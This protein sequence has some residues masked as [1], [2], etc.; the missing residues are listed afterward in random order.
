MTIK[1]NSAGP[2]AVAVGNDAMAM[3]EFHD[4]INDIKNEHKSFDGIEEN[5]KS[6]PNDAVT[7]SPDERD[8]EE[9]I[10]KCNQLPIRFLRAEKGNF[11]KGKKRFEETLEWRKENKMDE[12]LQAEW[13]HFD[14]VKENWPHYFHLRG[15]QNEPVYYEMPPKMKLKPM[16]AAG[17]KMKDLLHHYALVTE[18]MWQYIESSEEGKSIYVI[19]LQG[20]GFWDFAGEI[21]DFCRKASKFTQQHYPE[22]AGTIFVINVPTFFQ[23]IYN[24]MKPMADPVTLEKIKVV[25][26]K[27]AVQTA[28]REKILI[29]N[30]PPQYGGTSVPLGESPEEKMF[31]E[32]LD[33]NN[34]LH[35]GN[36]NCG[37]KDGDPP[38]QFCSFEVIPQGGKGF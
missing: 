29:E 27:E 15:K 18:F 26:G 5:G 19:D 2:I 33:H 7:A 23:V 32:L 20:M 10:N 17:L 28:L 30:I 36:A 9:T 25:S 1:E 16:R 34:A 37:G 3:G 6:V 13:A 8:K 24:V 21:I 35:N 12:I 11:E 14:T 4:A 38:C 31:K 22:R